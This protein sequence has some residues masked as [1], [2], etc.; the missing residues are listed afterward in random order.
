MYIDLTIVIMIWCTDRTYR[1]GIRA[2]ESRRES[3]TMIEDGAGQQYE[4]NQE[5]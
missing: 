5:S 4:K 1:T 3:K 2:T